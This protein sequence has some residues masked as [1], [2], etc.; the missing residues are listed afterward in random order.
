[1]RRILFLFALQL[2]LHKTLIHLS[3]SSSFYTQEADYL[4]DNLLIMHEGRKKAFGNSLFLK[5]TYGR[6]YQI[7]LVTD[8]GFVPAVQEVLASSLPGEYRREGV[9]DRQSNTPTIAIFII[10]S[11]PRSPPS[12]TTTI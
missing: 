6:G 10:I 3:S 1:M 4:G 7:N 9:T 8:P 2:H 12:S 11:L 5:E